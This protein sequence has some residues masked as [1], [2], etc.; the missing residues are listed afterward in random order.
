MISNAFFSWLLLLLGKFRLSSKQICKPQILVVSVESLWWV[1]WKCHSQGDGWHWGTVCGS[2]PVLRHY[3]LNL[4]DSASH[5]VSLIAQLVKNPPAM[6]ETP[7]HFLG[8]KIHWRRE[9]LPT[10]AFWPREFHGLYSSWSCK[11][12]DTTERL[13]LLDSYHLLSGY[14]ALHSTIYSSDHFLI[15]LFF[16]IRLGLFEKKKFM[17]LVAASFSCSRDLLSSL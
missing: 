11:E 13:S 7:V 6:Q 14:T 10:P 4:E 5:P 1:T 8:W 9:R 17:Y 15:A 3:L 2:W 16:K 12:S